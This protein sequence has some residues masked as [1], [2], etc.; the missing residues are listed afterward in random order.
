MGFQCV[1]WNILAIDIISKT[2]M[3]FFNN[4]EFFSIFFCFFFGFSL[5]RIRFSLLDSD[6][7]VDKSTKTI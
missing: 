1:N 4:L 6:Q 3:L 5:Q 2:I 7:N